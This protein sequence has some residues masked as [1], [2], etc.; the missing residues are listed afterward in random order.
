MVT[1]PT[2]P[3]IFYD[4]WRSEDFPLPKNFAPRPIIPE[5][6]PKS[7]TRKNNADL[8][9]GRDASE[10]EARQMIHAYHAAMSWTDWNAG[11]VLDE[12]DRTGL[13]QNTIVVFWS[14]HG[15]QL[16][17]KGKWSKAGSLFE[18][19]TRVPM[20][21]RAPG[22]SPAGARCERVVESIDLYPTLSTLC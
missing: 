9:I 13:S 14:D 6:F 5:G 16:G 11:R 4:A 20:I 2:A 7:S 21:V 18:A 12:L 3:R 1:P 19:G 10:A 22:I 15:Y 8:F 17:E